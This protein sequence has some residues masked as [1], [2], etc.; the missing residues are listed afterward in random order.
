MKQRAAH[1]A[2]HIFSWI[3]LLYTTTCMDHM[4]W[5]VVKDLV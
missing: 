5:V 1:V 3:S 4:W 2:D